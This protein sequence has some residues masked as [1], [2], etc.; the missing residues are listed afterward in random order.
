MTAQTD[1]DA[2]TR[3][4]RPTLLRDPDGHGGG[5]G[6]VLVDA[7]KRRPGQKPLPAVASDL[8]QPNAVQDEFLGLISHEL[9]TPVTSIYGNAILLASRLGPEAPG[10]A[11]VRDIADDA[12]R[13]LR[14]VENLLQ[15]ARL[16]S[17]STLHREPFVLDHIV[18]AAVGSRLRR[19]PDRPI[20]LT[21]S[22][23]SLVVLADAIALGMAVDN[24]LSNADK[25]GRPGMPTE[26][27]VTS[28]GE[29]ADVRVLDR[30]IGIPLDLAEDVFTAFFRADQAR[31]TAGGVGVGLAVCKRIVEAHDGQ[32]WAVSREGGGAEVGFSLPLDPETDDLGD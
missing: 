8:A 22:Q 14:I 19:H 31:R 10:G 29:R 26:V 13:L 7:T 11:M 27:V 1:A 32:I 4:P 16:G 6:G 15:L 30:G 3:A 18:Q 25:Y 9:R 24:L 28:D 23:P 2:K 12:D 20:Q 17:G 21:V 5:M